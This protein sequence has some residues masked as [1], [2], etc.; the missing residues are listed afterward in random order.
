MKKAPILLGSQRKLSNKGGETS[1]T[2][3]DFDDI[4]EWDLQYDLKRPDQMVVAD[5]SVL[6]QLFGD[7]YYAPPPEDILEGRSSCNHLASISC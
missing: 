4:E 1:P 3:A 7:K 5:D 6:H 2:V